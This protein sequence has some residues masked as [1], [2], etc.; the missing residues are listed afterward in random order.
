[1][2][3]GHYMPYALI[4]W[5]IKACYRGVKL[6]KDIR[7]GLIRKGRGAT[8]FRSESEVKECVSKGYDS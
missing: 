2:A 1:M 6:N 5:V 3:F 4:I 8:F 7:W